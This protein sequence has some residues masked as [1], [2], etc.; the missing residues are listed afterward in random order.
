ML[1]VEYLEL[2]WGGSKGHAPCR[3]LRTVMGG[4]QAKSMLP[5]EYLELS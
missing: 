2:W 3:V 5:V 4:G 1:H